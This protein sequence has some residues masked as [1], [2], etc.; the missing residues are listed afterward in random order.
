VAESRRHD[1][2]HYAA[3][4]AFLAV[5]TIAI[6]LVASALQGATADQAPPATPTVGGQTSAATTTT[7]EA[8]TS[9]QGSR[10]FYTVVAGD[11]FGAIAEKTGTSVTE[12]EQLNPDASSTSLHVGQKLRVA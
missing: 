2:Q 5:A 1:W 9:T 10:R 4:T 7:T 8:T 6:V 12:L 11:T 3:P